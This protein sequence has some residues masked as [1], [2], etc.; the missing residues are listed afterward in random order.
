MEDESPLI[1]KR[2]ATP[3][4][5]EFNSTSGSVLV[6]SDAVVEVQPDSRSISHAEAE[7]EAEAEAAEA[8][9]PSHEA[10]SDFEQVDSPSRSEVDPF[11]LGESPASLI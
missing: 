4:P 3:A 8:P 5:E 7:A 10:T 9:S 6:K 2:S 1:R 11:C